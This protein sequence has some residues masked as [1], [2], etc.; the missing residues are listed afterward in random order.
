MLYPRKLAFLIFLLLLSN[1]ENA[2]AQRRDPASPDSADARLI[3]EVSDY[4]EQ[5]QYT[6]ALEKGLAAIRFFQRSGNRVKEAA[7]NLEIAQ[8]YQFM[9]EQKGSAAY[10]HQGIDY[11]RM[12]FNQY[13]AIGD[14]SGE[15]KARIIQGII[16][17][18]MALVGYPA[19]YDSAMASYL[20]GLAR[21]NTTG[22]GKKYSGIF[23]NNI[24]QVYLEYKKDYP[25]ALHYLQEA[26][27]FNTGEH[28]IIR[29][30]FNYGNIAHLYQLMGNKQASLEYAYKT[31]DL[32]RQV[33]TS[34]RLLNAYQQL[35]DS[36]SSQGR[37]DSALHYY[38]LFD[39]LRDSISS[40]ATS[41][42]I[43]EAQAKYQAAE[44]RTLIGELNARNTLQRKRIIVLVVGLSLVLLF[45]AGL[46]FLFRRVQRQ[47][48]LISEQSGQLEVM[49]RELHHRVKNNLQII[50]SLLSLQSYKLRDEE[51]L[52]AIRLSQHRVQA[53][54]FIHQRLYT[55][56]QSR[57]VNMQE[58][59]E[60]LARSLVTAYGYSEHTLD[61]QIRVTRQWLDVDKALPLGLIANEVITN[62][63]KYAYGG[64]RRPALCIEFVE[65]REH[66]LFI[67]RDN[68]KGWD[69]QQWQQSSGSFGRQLVETL[70]RQLNATL[71]L[72]LKD[73]SVF[74]FTL[75]REKE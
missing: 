67:V 54:S 8:I 51:A 52:E 29:L 46:F 11:A 4:R 5:G 75:P 10:A 27:A 18:S 21:I 43:A 23:Y 59:L 30:S 72:N 25:S 13:V 19:Y 6:L 37:S 1:A 15:V 31:L 69:L 66:L 41:R 44:N 33:G 68:G 53:M 12:T 45:S 56:D 7:T 64:E 14:A 63:L 35:Y 62:A 26:V 65:T 71:Q 22:A 74:T 48:Q 38:L 20:D 36:Y 34:N 2:L 73:G 55:A 60:D 3:Q 24:S 58:Y 49:M 57:M 32:A 17:R 47:K 70:C 42:Q 16:F 39:N 50:S 61:L 28:N 9:A 40:L